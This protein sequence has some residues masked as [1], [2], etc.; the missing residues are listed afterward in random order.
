MWFHEPLSWIYNS[1]PGL[2]DGNHFRN[3]TYYSD[4]LASCMTSRYTVINCSAISMLFCEITKRLRT[5]VKSDF[6][7]EPAALPYIFATQTTIGGSMVFCGANMC[8]GFHEDKQT[9]NLSCHSQGGVNL[10]T[11][12]RRDTHVAVYFKIPCKCISGCCFRIYCQWICWGADILLSG[13]WF[14]TQ[15]GKSHLDYTAAN[16]P[17]ILV[18]MTSSKWNIFRVTGPLCGEFT[19]P[20]WIPLTKASDA[21]LWCSFWSNGWATVETPLIRDAVA[22][23]MTLL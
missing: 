19:G 22:V 2:A 13:L 9:P 8:G 14:E 11:I 18:M 12:Y 4:S 7:L 3:L 1:P 20:R 16:V 15:C 23:I 10:V 5:P 21:E 17:F 6:V